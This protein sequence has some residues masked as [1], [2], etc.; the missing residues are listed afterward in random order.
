[1]KRPLVWGHRGDCVHTPEN[2]L[3]AFERAVKDGAD[4]VELDIQLSRDGEIVVCHDETIDRTSDGHGWLKDFTLA[5]LKSFSFNQK[6]PEYGFQPIPTMREVL[7]LLRPTSLTIDIELKTSYPTFYPQIE[8][9][10]LALVRECGM[11]ERV[12]YSSFNHYSCQ[13]LLQLDPSLDVGFLYMDGTIGFPDYA[14]AHGAKAINPAG[15]NLFLPEGPMQRAHELGLQIR[16]WTV[17]TEE[18]VK[19]CIGK[20]VD[21]IITNDPARVRKYIQQF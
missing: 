15:Y 4:G 6:F 11:E 1:M 18:E 9:K 14:K 16:V 7:E 21:V 10:I 3:I 17:D 8:E 12:N 20:D 13:R 5:E 19:A 2:T